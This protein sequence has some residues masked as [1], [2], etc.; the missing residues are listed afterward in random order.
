MAQF[1]GFEIKRLGQENQD[2]PSIVVPESDDGA[3]NLSGATGGAYGQTLDLEGTIKTESEL[4]TRYRTMAMHPDVEAAIDD[5]VNESIV[6]SEQEPVSINLDDVQVSQSLKTKIYEEFDTILGMLKFQYNGYEVFRKWYVDGR[7]YHH[8]VIDRND[9]KAGIKELRFI[10]PR[11][12]RKVKETKKKKDQKTGVATTEMTNE[13]YVYNEKGWKAGVHGNMATGASAAGVKIAKDSIIYVTSGLT[14]ETNTLVISHLHKAIKPLNQLRMLEDAVVIYRIAR[15]PERRIFYIDVGN[16]PKM[17]AEQY[18]RD[19][20][21]K[22]K[23]RLVYDAGTGEVRD[24]RKF[25]TML[26]DYWLPRREGGRGTEI[27]TLPGGQN[28]GEMDDVNY[29][30]RK[31]YKSLNVPVTRMEA[32]SQFTLGRSNEISR[33][34]VK[35]AKFVERLRNKFSEVFFRALR[36]QLILKGII[37][38]EDWENMQHKIKFNYQRDNY[39]SEAKETEILMNRMNVLQQLEPYVGRFFSQEY[40]RKEILKMNDEDIRNTEQQIKQEAGDE[41]QQPQDD[42]DSEV[43]EA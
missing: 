30:Q 22:H 33:D 1:F 4:V 37:T 26:E 24:D 25:M 31:L 39:F 35:F 14:N 6:T 28:L 17:K 15:A 19:M 20:M 40:V 29:F 3:L 13:Y 38:E 18:L 34:E 2:T 11:K 23:N 5:I 7:I 42:N 9:V 12:I 43:P 27:T 16:L 21:V 32:E 10:D 41:S 8:V 36:V